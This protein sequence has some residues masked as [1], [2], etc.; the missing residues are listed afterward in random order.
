MKKNLLIVYFFSCI[1]SVVNAQNPVPNPGFEAWTAGDPDLWLTNNIPT[2]ATFIT[3]VSPGYSSAY[4][5]QGEVMNIAAT[6]LPPSL[7][8]SDNMGNGFPV[9]QAYGTLS[10]YYKLNSV[11]GDALFATVIVSDA[12]G[13]GI[14]TGIAVVSN[15]T[16]TFTLLNVPIA[17][18]ATN[19]ATCII[20]F[21]V[22]DTASAGANL[23]SYFIVD[24]VI[25]SGSVGIA[26]INKTPELSMTLQPNPAYSEVSLYYSVAVTGDAELSVVD[27][28]GKEVMNKKLNEV[29]LGMHTIVLDISSLK[30]GFYLCQLHTAQGLIV[31]RL[32]VRK[33]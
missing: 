24:D 16:N 5:A 12:T 6:N 19:A 8:S 15:P 33:N 3:Q 9:S 29:T 17:Y 26:E 32:Q 25:L 2:L 21:Q 10:F 20:Q 7:T 13:A 1:V 31:R 28:A 27:I 23:N 14:G 11:G 4:A 18:S 22:A 30:E